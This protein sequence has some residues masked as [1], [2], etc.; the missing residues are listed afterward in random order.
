[1]R[2]LASALLAL[3]LLVA[4]P[5]TA[6]A[7]DVLQST[8]P[9]DGASIAQL[10][11]E[12]TLTFEEA[13]LQLGSQVVVT[14]PSGPVTSGAP[15]IAGNVV[16]Q[17]LAPTA[18]AGDYSVSYRVSSDDGHPVTGT[19]RFHA[20]KGLDGSTAAATGGAQAQ[21]AQQAQAA[22][23]TQDPKSSSLA[24]VL[25]TVIGLLVLLAVGGFLL[26]RSRGADRSERRG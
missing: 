4:V 22:T 2:R 16:T 21:Q 7:H 11:E 14:G 3:G 5:T 15:K 19:F 6:V 8:N 1:M 23:T 26:L 25:I 17:A 10:P 24:P 20:A 13:P 12:V 9:A 18:P